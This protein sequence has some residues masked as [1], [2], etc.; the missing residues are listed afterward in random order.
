MIELVD[1]GIQSVRR[2]ASDLHPP[3][4]DDLGLRSAIEWQTGEFERRTGIECDTEVV[5]TLPLSNRED[6]PAT[7]RA[8]APA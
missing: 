3:V 7:D 1:A 8:P 6:D 4:L 5:L 2:I